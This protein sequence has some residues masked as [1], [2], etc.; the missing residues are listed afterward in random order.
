MASSSMV[1]TALAAFSLPM[2]ALAQ[3]TGKASATAQYESNTN[4][5]DLNSG[6]GAPSTGNTRRADTFYA[7]GAQFD[8]AYSW[9]RQQFY[10]IA[11]TTEYNYQRFTDL[12]H[13]GYN[14]DA[15]LK[16]RL[17]ESL[18]G[19]LDVT[20]TR[21]MVPF[22][23]LSGPAALTLSLLTEQRETAQIGLKLNSQWK[24]EGSAYTS[25]TD[26]PVV[27]APNLQLNQ[28]AATASI[29]YLGV[30]GLTSGLTA[31]YS[32]GDYQGSTT[33]SNPSFSETTAGILA[34]YKH[35]RTTFD[36]QIGYSR[37][38]SANSSDNTSGLTGLVDFTDQLTARTSVTLKADRLINSYV[39]NS[40]SEI[41][42]DLG[43]SLLWQATYKSAV[44]L[45]YTF[46]YRDFPRQGNNPVGSLRVDIQEYATLG[47]NYQP[48]RWLLIKPY[49]NAQTR[50]STFIGGHYSSN[51]Y[52]VNVTVMTPDNRK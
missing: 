1:C 2:P 35:Y 10:A 40:G 18:D 21:N 33:L 14:V 8:A 52:G 20:R 45:G 30:G 17:A 13:I 25:K 5:F 41:D 6:S 22:Y 38:V 42:T 23:N 4:V 50:R 32:S 26:Q 39:L 27:G 7:Y 43:A 29:D 12:N 47:I 37:R 46:S 16:W 24:L 11:S 31:G 34:K 48:R 9:R 15:G 49:Y 28:T 51:I 36:G 19:K 3:F 44:A